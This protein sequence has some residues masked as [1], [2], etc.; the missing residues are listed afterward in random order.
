MRSGLDRREQEEK[1][2]QE[3]QAELGELL[4][5]IDAQPGTQLEKYQAA[6]RNIKA[7]NRGGLLKLFRETRQEPAEYRAGSEIRTPD[8]PI[9]S[10]EHSFDKLTVKEDQEDTTA[11]ATGGKVPLTL[12][13]RFQ[14]LVLGMK[15]METYVKTLEK[16]IKDT[17]QNSQLASEQSQKSATEAAQSQ[18]LAS[19]ISKQVV[20]TLAKPRPYDLQPS[21]LQHYRQ[22]SF[23][24]WADRFEGASRNW[25]EERKLNE[26]M[27]LLQGR[28]EDVVVSKKRDEWTAATLLQ[29]CRDRLSPGYTKVQIELALLQLQAKT[30]DSPDD[31]MKRIEEVTVKMDSD[32][33]TKT[34]DRLKHTAFMRMIQSHVPM[35]HH[36]SNKAQEPED[37]YEALKLARE[38]IQ[39]HGHESMYMMQIAQQVMKQAGMN[40]P[41]ID[42][43]AILPT[44]GMSSAVLQLP[45]QTK[46][47][48]APNLDQIGKPQPRAMQTTE[49]LQSESVCHY[50]D[51]AGTDNLPEVQV[52]ARYFD[53]G[54]KPTDEEVIK[55]HNECERFRRAFKAGTIY[56]GYGNEENSH[57]RGGFSRGNSYNRGRGGN[58]QPRGNSYSRGRGN[59]SY[60][61]GR[62][63][64]SSYNNRDGNSHP[65]SHTTSP[66]RERGRG[67]RGSSGGYSR[68]NSYLKKVT[69]KH[70]DADGK[71][72]YREDQEYDEPGYNN[73][74]YY[75][76]GYNDEGYYGNGEQFPMDEAE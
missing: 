26:L 13:E 58:Y 4:E 53:K 14:E 46:A 50:T 63:N 1:R 56:P 70:Y 51:C 16:Q 20:E 8:T 28:A 24:L 32:L 57:N 29:A 52:E 7:R 25:D 69:V 21:K 27:N 9:R 17:E 5:W 34:I 12:E 61:R 76:D 72:V 64:N 39:N 65:G 15:K 74:G 59:D 67:Y 36:I 10:L 66:T 19:T 3:L 35:Y 18:A 31:V 38:Y 22:G 43:R 75:G 55:R 33:P 54:Q 48:S 60:N 37:P 45:G 40:V 62:G 6:L 73:Q 68:G 2:Y 23:K 41:N 71:E 44:I 30:E 42:M 49:K 47:I 11:M